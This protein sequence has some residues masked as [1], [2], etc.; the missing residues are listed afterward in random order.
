MNTKDETAQAVEI[1]QA[2]CDELILEAYANT[3]ELVDLCVRQVMKG[4]ILKRN[5]GIWFITNTPKWPRF[6]SWQS[7]QFDTEDVNTEDDLKRQI[8]WIEKGSSNKLL[9]ELSVSEIKN[10]CLQLG[11][12]VAGKSRKADFVA[13]V[14][15]AIND[16]K[17]ISEMRQLLIKYEIE[18]NDYSLEQIRISDF[19]EMGE[20][21]L[22]RHFMIH[23]HRNHWRDFEENAKERP[24][25]MFDAIDDG[26]T[27]KECMKLDGKI[28]RVNDPFWIE[29]PVPCEKL[30]CR[31]TLRSLSEQDKKGNTKRAH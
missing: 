22:H 5:A 1:A 6:E 18:N 19:K 15:I 7:D 16:N 31:C 13:A 17:L 24:Y 8:K 14:S 10:V 27:P 3:A 21:F 23:M 20:L 26:R 30:L 9:A 4:D 2:L 28:K 11:V 25:L 29:H 12:E